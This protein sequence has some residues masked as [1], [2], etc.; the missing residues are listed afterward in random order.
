[1]AKRYQID[2][3]QAVT[4]NYLA[5]ILLTLVFFRPNLGVSV[6]SGPLSIYLLLGILLPSLF[7][8]IGLAIRFTGIVRT[9]VAQRL[10][11]FVPLLASFFFFG[12]SLNALKLTGIIVGLTAVVCS[13]PWTEKSTRNENSSYSIILLL[14]VFIGMGLIDVLFK[15]VALNKTVPYTSSLLYIYLLS[16]IIS[17]IILVSLFLAKKI[18]F[19]WIN[20]FCGLILGLFNFGNILF[21]LKAHQA[22]SA[23]P[24]LI[25]T[26][27]NI[28]VIAIGALVGLIIFK[29]KLSTLNKVGIALALISIIIL[30]FS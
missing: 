3:S 6:T 28:G 30:S 13:I 20:V 2:I 21:Y 8:I 27:M 17:M 11:L 7:M 19:H 10:S 15:Q 12:E 14:T 25:F 26:S 18:R 22:E 29:E 4:W 5:A 23:R 16:F 9:D 24:S 1:M